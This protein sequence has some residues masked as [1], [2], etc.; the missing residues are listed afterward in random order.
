MSRFPKYLL[1]SLRSHRTS[2]GEHPSFP[3]DEELPFILHTVMKFFDKLNI[4][5]NEKELL[6]LMVNL[7]KEINTKNI[8]CEQLTNDKLDINE[9]LEILYNHSSFF[10]F[11]SPSC[12]KSFSS[13]ILLRHLMKAE[14]QC[15]L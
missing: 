14:Q 7:S 2:L 6:K 3:P 4:E 8:S 5:E 12:D 11:S 10:N 13:L 1:K 9:T 15:C